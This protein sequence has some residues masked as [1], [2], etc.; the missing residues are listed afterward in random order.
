MNVQQKE[1]SNVYHFCNIKKFWCKSF[2]FHLGVS[3]HTFICIVNA[4]AHFHCVRTIMDIPHQL[5]WVS[6]FPCCI[7]KSSL[8]S[9]QLA[10][11]DQT[12]TEMAFAD[13]GTFTAHYC[14][15]WLETLC[16][17]STMPLLLIGR[18]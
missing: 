17:P 13:S 3:F 7:A 1:N 16:S 2:C 6:H 9:Q 18:G 11:V 12:S 4:V 15:P 8:M 10:L 5:P 14:E